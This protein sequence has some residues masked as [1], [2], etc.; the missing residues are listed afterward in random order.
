MEMENKV[1][2]KTKVVCL[3]GN[4]VEHSVSP[5]LHNTISGCLGVD[6]VYT[7]FRVD[8][9]CLESAVKGL[10]ALNVVGFNVTVPYKKDIIGF[11]DHTS[12]EA[13]LMGAVNTVKIT[14]GRLYGYNTDAEGFSRSFKEETGTGFAGKSVAII[15]AGGAARAIAIKAAMEG[16]GKIYLINRTP[17][18]ARDIAEMVSNNMGTS[19]QY[20]S[21]GEDAYI[22]IL[23]K[24][25]IL[26]NSTSAGMF[27]HT[28][29]VPVPR[30][31]VFSKNQIVYD[32]IYNP[33][34]TRFLAEAEKAGCKTVNGLGM[35]FYQGVY[36]YE[37]WTGMN[38]P[39]SKVRDLFQ[40]FMR[41]K[42]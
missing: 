21:T 20:C 29:E 25:D 14:D 40:S 3:I 7:A 38:L 34:K 31:P 35:L 18:K 8:K 22:D 42:T 4:P 24:C 11:L 39:E 16:A 1:T 17:E 13:L 12:K 23:A 33:S 28:D 5:V 6:L 9:E 41:I 19:T 2:G 15:G 30:L 10:K 27:P 26:I 37:I 36:A 32:V